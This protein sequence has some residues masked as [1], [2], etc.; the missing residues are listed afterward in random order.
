MN[1]LD[2]SEL[3]SA[4]A[5]DEVSQTQR[6]FVEEHLLSCLEC[7]DDLA[8]Y[9]LI[10]HQLTGLRE[11]SMPS[12]VGET[13]MT[14]IHATTNHRSRVPR[15][16]RPVVA[17]SAVAAAIAIAL[18][19]TLSDGDDRNGIARAYDAVAELES[20]RMTGTTTV[21][22]DDQNF[23]TTFDW[24]FDGTDR[25]S[26]TL[27]GPDGDT[28]FFVDGD[29]QYVRSQSGGGGGI[30][31]ILEDS[32]LSPVPTREGTLR[33]LE[34]LI[35]VIELP[36]E[37]INGVRS[38]HYSG[39]ID[40]GPEFDELLAAFDE[41]SEEYVQMKAFFD[42]QRQSE[43]AI[44]LWISE[45][46]F[47]IQRLLIDARLATANSSN[48][49]IAHGGWMISRTVADYS[50]FNEPVDIAPPLTPTGELEPGWLSSGS[51]LSSGGDQAP[52]PVISLETR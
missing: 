33:F 8:E 31:V 25:V 20:Y 44:E 48:G 10:R 49:V 3:L 21:I 37:T 26:G 27:S 6:E 42:I 43:I 23:E 40:L 39:D 32:L 35:G 50:E 52:A 4:Y 45:E 15:I 19:I 29:V 24:T 7:R 14:A 16:L 17:A 46:D 34:S 18:V 5:N 41:S 1:H 13:T 47:Q 9:K 38:L 36:T 30:V 2:I 28:D 22:Q 11:F 51:E 12:R